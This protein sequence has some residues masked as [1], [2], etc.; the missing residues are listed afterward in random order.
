[1]RV[2]VTDHLRSLILSRELK[3]GERLVQ[4]ELAERLGVSR[5]PIREALQKLASEGLVTFSPYKGATVAELSL[6]DVED[7]YSV[8]T[9]LECHAGYLAAQRITAEELEQL[10]T[11]LCEME[12][13][14]EQGELLHMMELNRQFNSTLFSASQ[15]PRLCELAVKYMHL[16]DLY[17]RIHFSIERLAADCIVEHRQLLEALRGRDAGAV[18]AL[19]RQQVARSVS[20]LK[21]FIKGDSK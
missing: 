4:S 19:T 2:S 1:M 12:A 5:T 7:I 17:R 18:E 8:R 15:Q 16:A 21:D 3:P 10:E 20:A 13:A 9:A 11:L 14:F 6:A